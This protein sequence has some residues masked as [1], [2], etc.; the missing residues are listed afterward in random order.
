LYGERCV[1]IEA[2]SIKARDKAA[3][4]VAALI[5]TVLLGALGMVM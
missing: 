5:T 1:I 3:A 2:V 4:G